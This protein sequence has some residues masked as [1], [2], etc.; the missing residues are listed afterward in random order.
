M[1]TIRLTLAY[2]GTGFRGW[3]RQSDPS[4]R[5]I[6][7]V[8]AA[9]LERVLREP[10]KLA[11]AGRTDAGVHARGQVT[12]FSTASSIPPE[13]LLKALNSALAPEV[14]VLDARDAPEDFHA[15]YSAK[16]R[17]YVYRIHE[18]TMPDPFTARFVWHRPGHL[19]LTPMREAARSLVGERD[20]ASFCR[21][22]EGDRS[23]IRHLRQLTVVRHGD[24]LT[25]RSVANAFLRQMVRTLVGTLVAVGE[26]KLEAGSIPEI[27]AA[28]DRGAAGSPAPTRGLTLERVVYPYIAE[29]LSSEDEGRTDRS[30]GTTTGRP[31][32]A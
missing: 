2:D 24:V 15:R 5:T 9:Q 25:I 12:S 29:V 26:G 31:H 22:P 27:L 16:S 8:V 21:R 28:Q 18:A 20:F 17:E 6:E 11:V 19:R 23:T 10:V 13:R 32:P 14:V 3:A 30:G 7:G 4:T 1:R